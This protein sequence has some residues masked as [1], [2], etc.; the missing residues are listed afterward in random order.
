MFQ[1]L[2]GLLLGFFV[3]GLV[4]RSAFGWG[5]SLWQAFQEYR[6]AAAYPHLNRPK[7]PWVFL[8]LVVLHSGPWIL[9]MAAFGFFKLLT[10]PHQPW[11]SWLIGGFIA[12]L[13]PTAL[14]I[15]SVR[16][17]QHARRPQELGR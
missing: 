13:A 15:A 5:L 16:K 8:P 6:E 17:R 12:Y 11:H 2:A 9:A 1:A 4:V 10:S 7:N 3:G 14:T